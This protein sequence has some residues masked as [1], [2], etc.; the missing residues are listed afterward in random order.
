MLMM[1]Q[2]NIQGRAPVYGG[3]VMPAPGP[4]N[5][6]PSCILPMT[7]GGYTLRDEVEDDNNE[8]ERK[9]DQPEGK[10]DE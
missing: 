8:E 7:L 4:N 10:F 1:M 9:N 3:N 5:R 6:P 2:G